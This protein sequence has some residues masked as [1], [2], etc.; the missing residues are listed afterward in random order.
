MTRSKAN[1]LL[2]IAILAS[3]IFLNTGWASENSADSFSDEKN[4]V[5]PL[6]E[7]VVSATRIQAP[8]QDVAANITVVGREVIEKMPAA[9]AAEV[10]QYIP[11]VY[12]EFNGGPGSSATAR[13]QG[14]EIRHV[15]VYVDGVPLNLLANPITDL[16]YVPVDSIDR[17]EVYKGAA[18]SAW[19]PSLGGVINIITKEPDPTKPFAGDIRTSYGKAHTSK[20]RG[21]ISGIKDR[22]GYLLSVTHDESDGFIADSAYNQS[23]VYAKVNYEIDTS[24]RLNFVYS[25]DDGH[26]E[27]PVIGYPEFWDDIK[28]ERTYQR[29][30]FE[31]FLS[32]NLGLSMEARHQDYDGRVEDVYTHHREIFN[33]YKEESWGGSVRINYAPNPANNLNLGFD[34]D[35]GRFDWIYYTRKYETGNWALY[36]NDT[37]KRENVSLNAGLRYDDNKDFGSKISPSA[38][39]VFRF[40]DDRILVRAQVAK[41]F[42]AP[43]V[44][45]VKDP[46]YGTPDLGPETAVNYQLGSDVQ[47][48]KFLRLELNLFYADVEDLIR[49]DTDARKFTNIDKVIRRGVEAILSAVFDFG[50]D[51]SLS[52]SFTDVEDDRTGK[53]IKDIPTTEYHVSAAY[54]YKWITQ[55]VFGKYA[56][57][58]STYPETRDKKFVFDY[59][60]NIRLPRMK[61]VGRPGLFCAVYNIFNTK[62]RLPESLAPAR[63]MGRGRYSTDLLIKRSRHGQKP[64]FNHPLPVLFY[65]CHILR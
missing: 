63:P 39:L 31:T 30:L 6:Q 13:I 36:A 50:L 44:S 61:Y 33:D 29:I 62:N 17:I 52:G 56:D 37:F 49:Y 23:A 40:Q 20:N 43:P 15:A 58:N 53:E 41:G 46:E 48:L 64:P 8:K 14:S 19:G 47:I 5:Y 11:G 65:I 28:Q 7:I 32:E 35:W 27:D 16:S 25:F 38:G 9:T 54:T 4:D 18:S 59:L 26:N 2:I 60:L 24:S 57:Y 3:V 45:W 12:V 21:N 55:S 51:L 1:H 10:L 22:F 42:S 34:G